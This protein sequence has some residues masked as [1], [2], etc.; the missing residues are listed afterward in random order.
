M[1]SS[2]VFLFLF[3]LRE[4]ERGTCGQGMTL[5]Q[6]IGV[7]KGSGCLVSF[8]VW[9]L[10]SNISDQWWARLAQLSTV[11]WFHFLRPSFCVSCLCFLIF[12]KTSN[13][14]NLIHYFLAVVFV[15]VFLYRFLAIIN[16]IFGN[17]YIDVDSLMPCFTQKF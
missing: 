4:R 1:P 7:F 8:A 13:N 5:A 11:I 14:E 12:S 10:Q 16:E 15:L 2:W 9:P 6:K 3:G 17:D